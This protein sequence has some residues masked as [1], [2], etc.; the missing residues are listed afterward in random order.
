MLEI[1]LPSLILADCCRSP[2]P[3]TR[4]VQPKLRPRAYLR[5]R[6]LSCQQPRP[7]RRRNHRCI[8]GRKRHRRKRHRQTPPRRLCREPPPKLD[9]G[10]YPARHQ[11][12]PRASALHCGK[13][14]L[15]QAA[16]HGSLKAR[17]QI[18]HLRGQQARCAQLGDPLRRCPCG[19][20][21]RQ[22]PLSCRSQHAVPLQMT[23]DRRLDPG[24]RKINVRRMGVRHPTMPYRRKPERHRLRIA[25]RRQRI[26]PW[27][28][29]IRQPEQ[30]SYLVKR[31]A[32]CIVHR[33]P[34]RTVSKYPACPLRQIQVRVAP[35]NHQCHHRRRSL[36]QQ[37]RRTLHQHS[38]D[39]PFQV[40]HCQQ[41]LPERK[42]Q[43][44]RIRNPHQQRPRQPRPF[45]HRDC[46]KR[47]KPQPRL[48]FLCLGHR[49]PH[50]RHNVP[51]M[52]SAGQF[53][54]H[55]SIQRVQ[56]HLARDHARQHLCAAPH[57]RR[58]RFVARA[59][60]TQN[61]PRA[62]V[63]DGLESHAG[64]ATFVGI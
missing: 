57:H 31:L 34:Q 52:L 27:A 49:R 2:R 1:G 33:A 29:R 39:V 13:R 9:V 56:I 8:V 16:D 61:Q 3:R 15:H 59:L 6:P 18:Q 25:Q 24:K 42:G 64:S 30:L 40:I 35:R 4:A 50:H 41:R 22:P 54:H 38:I 17:D 46:V 43:R 58:R 36:R 44:L 55:P 20:R 48:P 62:A 14:L 26:D 51:Q 7:R 37:L 47:I 60:N 12:R 19:V 63:V 32:R 5:V 21:D 11:H 45:R 10:C 28:T 53:R 23:Q